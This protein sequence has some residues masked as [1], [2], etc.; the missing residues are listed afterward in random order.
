M[1]DNIKSLIVIIFFAT[2]FFYFARQ[3]SCSI[4]GADNFT[5]RRNIWFAMTAAGF[6]A[7]NFWL[8]VVIVISILIYNKPR[9]AKPLSLY[10]ITLFV[11]P[12]ATVPI[13]GMGVVNYIFELSHARVLSL[14]ILLPAF[15]ALRR[16]GDGPALGSI[17]PD[18]AF[19]AYLFL[20]IV[21]YSRGNN[22]AEAT[23]TSAIRETFYVFI[24]VFL[25][26][27]VIT[28]SLRSMQDFRDAFLSFLLAVILIALLSVFESV[29][30][31]ILYQPLVNSLGLRG[32]MTNYMGRGDLTR[33]V[34]TSGQA[35]ALG[36][37]MVVGIGLY[38]FLQHM[39]ENK[40][41]RR[42]GMALLIGGLI[43]S[44]SRG[45][46]VGAVALILVYFATGRYVVSRIMMLALAV[47]I[48]F[49]LAALFP[50]GEKIINMLPFVGT[51]ETENVDYRADLFTNSM[52][53]IQRY[54]WFGSTDYLKAPEM[55][56]MI[57]GEGIIDVVNSYIGIALA[58]GFTG[59]GLFVTFFALTLSGIFRAMRLISDKDSAEYLLGRALVATL[60]GILVTIATVSSIT[61]IPIVYWSAAGMGVAYA[62]MVRNNTV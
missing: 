1:L 14:V 50:G 39:I 22:F 31:W 52:I 44:V 38:F 21:L 19:I 37:L 54:P 8:Y 45:P 20:Y 57:Q 12:M 18:K 43:G 60:I 2:I 41:I 47:L 9:E 61:L 55:L 56:V 7:Y 15:L 24:D 51:S 53:I 32:A 30:G 17:A 49:S 5:R 35:I 29:K 48:F 26:Y 4:I 28:R 27:Y 59:L 34:V 42:F 23:F 6:L 62:Q 58:Q 13:P 46:W 3:T 33:A 40:T 11:L 16:K 25:P 36:Y 10:F